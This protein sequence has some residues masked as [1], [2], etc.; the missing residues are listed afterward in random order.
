MASTG[1]RTVDEL[2]A[3]PP[4]LTRALMVDPEAETELCDRGYVVIDLLD[5]A[6]VA[7]LRDFYVTHADRGDLNPEGAYNEMY[8]EFTIMNSRN[9]FRRDAFAIIDRIVSARAAEHLIDV[10]AVIANFVNKPPGGGVVPVH[11]NIS[12]VEEDEARSVSVWVALVDITEE[13]GPLQFVD[14]TH[15][16][17]RG[18]RGPWAYSEFFGIDQATIDERFRSVP[19]RAGQAIVLDDAVVHYSPPNSSNERR[20]AIQLVMGPDELPSTYYECTSDDDEAMHLDHLEID[21]AYFFDF[22]NGTGDRTHAELLD[23]LTIPRVRHD[24][25]ALDAPA[26]TAPAPTAPASGA[27]EPEAEAEAD[28]EPAGGKARWLARLRAALRR[29]PARP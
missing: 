22:W 28:A 7:E 14:G 19:I 13:N 11:Q 26:P 2:D 12:V 21:P 8:G 3:P 5:P 10:R 15:R 27:L 4:F 25:S 24:A 17:L 23:Q 18:K 1:P 16:F 29:A 9:D 20:L 6:E